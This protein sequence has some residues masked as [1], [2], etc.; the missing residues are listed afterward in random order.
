MAAHELLNDLVVEALAHAERFD[1]TRQPVPWL[2][3]IAANLVKR[4]QSARAR[5]HRR[6]PLVRD[7]AGEGSAALADDEIFDR[8]AALTA[9]PGEPLETQQRVDMLLEPLS[10]ADR[11][12]VQLAILHD[13]DGAALARELGIQPGAARV[14]LHR[15]LGRLRQAAVGLGVSNG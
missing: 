1:A 5:D 2:L 14:R 7:I 10:K 3:G 15:A 6:E 9:D 4:R 11:R 13:L 12:L 8:V